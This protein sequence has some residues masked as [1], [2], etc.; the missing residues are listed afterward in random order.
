[1]A[2]KSP[3][4]PKTIKFYASVADIQNAI[5]FRGNGDGGRLVLEVPRSESGALLLLQQYGTEKLLQ[6]TLAVIDKDS[7]AE[8]VEA[9]QDSDLNA[10]D[11]SDVMRRSIDNDTVNDEL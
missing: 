11:W 7:P 2:K 3:V 6:I 4:S 10:S 5:T 9:E 8:L 1:M